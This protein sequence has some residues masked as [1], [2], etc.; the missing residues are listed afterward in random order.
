MFFYCSSCVISHT[1]KC[2]QKV[3]NLCRLRRPVR[4][5]HFFTSF[6][7]KILGTKTMDV[8]DK[9]A[10]ITNSQFFCA[11]VYSKV[12][13]VQDWAGRHTW[14]T[15]GI[16]LF[17]PCTNMDG[18]SSESKWGSV[19]WQSHPRQ[20]NM[21]GGAWG[22]LSNLRNLKLCQWKG[23]YSSK[24]LLFILSSIKNMRARAVS[25]PSLYF[26]YKSLNLYQF[27]SG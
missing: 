5:G 24:L 3:L 25:D 16:H 10:P 14:I 2:K 11:L 1:I 22:S 17:S 6:S 19:G 4:K 12:F 21:V 26:S 15:V 8:W 7:R 20:W 27:C 23:E 18:H 13:L 9:T